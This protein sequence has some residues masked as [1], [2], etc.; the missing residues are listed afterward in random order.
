MLTLEEMRARKRILGYTNLI[1]SQ[2]SGVPLGTVQKIM[3]GVTKSPRQNTL[4]ALS[5]A[6]RDENQPVCDYASESPAH[7]EVREALSDY[8]PHKDSYTIDDIE[9]LPEYVRAELI[10]GQ[11]YYMS[12]PSRTHQRIVGELHLIVANYIRAHNGDCEVYIPPFGVYLF[13]D[14][15]ALVEPDLTIVCDPEKLDEKGCHGAPDW[16]VEVVSPSSKKRDHVIKLNKY[17]EA[18]VREYWI[19]FPEKRV[20]LV[21]QFAQDEKEEDVTIY[22]FDD[23]IP[24]GIYPDLF[25]QL[26][27][28]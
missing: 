16:I 9:S 20:V 10:D 24:C 28:F 25:V 15:S 2:K 1:L 13:P 11:I 8:L 17:R 4:R 3:A 18:G 21:Y 6:L 22:S 23:D 14:N 5:D 19:V 7:L 26:T 27:G 12:V